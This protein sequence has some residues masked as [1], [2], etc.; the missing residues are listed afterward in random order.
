LKRVRDAFKRLANAGYVEKD[1]EGGWDDWHERL[2]CIHGYS[3]TEKGRN[4]S[5][6][7]RFEREEIEYIERSLHGD[8]RDRCENDHQTD[9]RGNEAAGTSA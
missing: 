6:W 8:G 1:Y 4:T 7:K 2:Y 3:L 9:D 5:I